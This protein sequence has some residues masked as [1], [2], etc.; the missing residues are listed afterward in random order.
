MLMTLTVPANKGSV[1]KVL[2]HHL[3]N[4]RLRFSRVMMEN[5]LGPLGQGFTKV[6]S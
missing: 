4:S 2:A 5:Y 6:P 3:L 1:L